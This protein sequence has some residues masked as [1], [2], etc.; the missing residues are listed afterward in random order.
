M[1]DWSRRR[2]RHYRRG[3]YTTFSK[4]TVKDLYLAQGCCNP[5]RVRHVGGL[6]VLIR[7]SKIFAARSTNI[8][9]PNGTH[10]AL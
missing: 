9:I 4:Y 10:T 1:P 6:G 5:L 2:Y 8:E 7:A 3:I